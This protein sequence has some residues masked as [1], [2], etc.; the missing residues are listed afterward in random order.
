MGVYLVIW[1]RAAA[2]VVNILV[3]FR[4]SRSSV[5]ALGWATSG[6]VLG[7]CDAVGWGFGTYLVCCEC[8]VGS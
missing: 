3:V 7:G 2:G 1:F 8:I 4:I 5:W 6:L